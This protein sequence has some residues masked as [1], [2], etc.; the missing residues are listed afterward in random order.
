MTI[1]WY[2]MHISCDGVYISLQVVLQLSMYVY[3]LL[4]KI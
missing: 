1:Y 4:N 2:L 3:S